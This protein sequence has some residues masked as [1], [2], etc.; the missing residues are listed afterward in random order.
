MPKAPKA[1]LAKIK[2]IK[3][4]YAISAKRLGELNNPHACS[5]CF[6]IRD[7]MHGTGRDA[8]FSFGMA[9]ILSRLDSLQKKLIWSNPV[10]PEF[11]HNYKHMTLIKSSR[12]CVTDERTGIDLSG[13]PDLI[14]QATNGDLAIVDLKSSKPKET[15]T[16]ADKSAFEK[17]AAIYGTQ[18]NVYAW[19]LEKSGAGR[20][21]RLALMYLWPSGLAIENGNV[22]CVFDAT[23]VALSLDETLV[24]RLLDKARAIL[25]SKR[26]PEPRADCLDCVRMAH[27]LSVLGL[28]SDKDQKVLNNV[29]VFVP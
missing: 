7:K 12:M 19:M 29:K 13:V 14:F 17:V 8:P 27:M 15:P 26:I 11:L 23:E 10:L 28:E 16:S 4:E 20:V 25:T 1:K 18:L 24:P 22:N 21:T 9:G 5:R 6:W 2:K 3:S